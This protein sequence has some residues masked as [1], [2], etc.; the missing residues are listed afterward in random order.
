[1]ENFTDKDV[2]DFG[3][4]L[5]NVLNK[6][7]AGHMVEPENIDEEKAKSY[8]D[9][10]KRK[11]E[12]KFILITEQLPEKGKDII[13]IDKNGNKHYCFRCNCHNQNCTEWRCS[14][15][16]FGIITDIKKWIYE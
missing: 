2:K 14:I 4:I 7:T 8:E 11:Q 12:T 10:A 16:G 5:F 1:M 9:W 3:D 6:L 13:G 15:T